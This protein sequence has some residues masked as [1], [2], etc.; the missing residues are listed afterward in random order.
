L[1]AFYVHSFAGYQKAYG[2]LG[3]VVVLLL[4]FYLSSFFVVLGA[5]INAELERQTK[6]DTTTGPPEPLGK[7]GAYAADT[8]GPTAPRALQRQRHGGER[9]AHTV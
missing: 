9:S 5:E 6:A 3:S 7:R 1:F 8:V 2:A 4:W